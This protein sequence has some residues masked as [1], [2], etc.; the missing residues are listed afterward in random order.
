MSKQTENSSVYPLIEEDA[1]DTVKHLL[2][3]M[4]LCKESDSV[5][6]VTKAGEGNM[7]VVLRVCI[8]DKSLI[9]KQSR[10]WVAKYPSI[11]APEETNHC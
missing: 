5:A 9:V 1:V 8:A 6:S 10:A 11:A 3:D 7:N 2:R 4:Q